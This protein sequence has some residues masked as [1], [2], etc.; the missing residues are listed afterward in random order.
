[1]TL[2]V[3]R[4][5]ADSAVLVCESAADKA[6]LEDAGCTARLDAQRWQGGDDACAF[7]LRL[8]EICGTPKTQ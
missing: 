7:T 3:L 4:E 6:L 8:R 5:G 2:R 1:M